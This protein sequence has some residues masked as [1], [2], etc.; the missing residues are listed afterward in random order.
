M[1]MAQTCLV[2]VESSFDQ[3]IT[4][5]TDQECKDH[6]KTMLP[7]ECTCSEL[8][9]VVL[10]ALQPCNPHRPFRGSKI[11]GWEVGHNQGSLIL[12]SHGSERVMMG[13]AKVLYGEVS[14]NARPCY[15]LNVHVLN[16]VSLYLRHCSNAVRTDRFVVQR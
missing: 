16:C 3:F 6:A 9:V 10:A 4:I 15:Q 2:L 7:A 11:V 1:Q 8:C 13:D 12:T 14:Q 5:G